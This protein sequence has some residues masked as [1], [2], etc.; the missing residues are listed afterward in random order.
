M[1]RAARAVI[2]PH[3]TVGAATRRRPIT[4]ACLLG[5][6]ASWW[7]L[8]SW[9]S[10]AEAA[11]DL[12]GSSLRVVE[13]YGSY[14]RVEWIGR[15]QG[16]DATAG[17]WVDYVYISPRSA[18]CAEAI[19][20]GAFAWPQSA[21]VA[22]GATYT[23]QA[24]VLI[25]PLPLGSYY[26]IARVNASGSFAET[27][28]AN[29]VVATPFR[30]APHVDLSPISLTAPASATTQQ[31]ISVSWTVD[32]FVSPLPEDATAD[33]WQ[34]NL[35]ISPSPTCCEGAIFLGSWSHAGGLTL[36]ERY[37]Q[38][39]TVT[40]PD[41]PAG[42][43]YVIVRIDVTDAQAEIDEDNAISTRI[44]ITTP[45]LVATSLRA[46]GASVVASA[47]QVIPASWIVSNRGTGP[48]LAS[49]QDTLYI[50]PSPTCC[51]GAMPLGTWPS[52]TA[53]VPHGSY[54]QTRPITVP[55]LAAGSY[56]LI[57]WTNATGSLHEEDDDNSRLAIPVTIT[58]PISCRRRCRRRHRR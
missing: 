17:G 53:L 54:Q 51:A 27:N 16:P 5:L 33:L 13:A 46:P 41:L 11:P 24:T 29:N 2:A 19:L 12:V 40:V 9:A 38:T 15:N 50:S 4:R 21:P 32:N 7:S 57:V 25:P 14:A 58:T 43:Y 36:N 1:A 47:Q 37:T 55:T 26:L 23:H 10:S 30:I 8:A 52:P 49:W 18:C 31:S 22:P 28:T 34:D 44:R 3:T 42:D 48:T 39:Q 35:Y 6:L 45:D 20:L 56:Y